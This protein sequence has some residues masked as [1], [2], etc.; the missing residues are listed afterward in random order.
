MNDEHLSER[1]ISTRRF[2]DAQIWAEAGK[3]R[4]W[5]LDRITVAWTEEELDKVNIKRIKSDYK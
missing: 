3:T 1:I 5:Y 2:A 4:G